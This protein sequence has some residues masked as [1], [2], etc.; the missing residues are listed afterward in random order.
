MRGSELKH[1]VLL[2]VVQLASFRKGTSYL[3]FLAPASKPESAPW[4]WAGDLFA[5]EDLP[6][7][8]MDINYWKRSLP[9][10]GKP[11]ESKIL[12]YWIGSFGNMPWLRS[13]LCQRDTRSA[14]S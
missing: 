12:K 8:Y 3:L 10:G 9:S 11:I 13:S 6:T 1:L 2:V 7:S 14:H 4:Q 5:I